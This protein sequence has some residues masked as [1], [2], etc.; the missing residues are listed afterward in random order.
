M[1]IKTY[2]G[3]DIVGEKSHC[4]ATNGGRRI[5]YSWGNHQ[6]CC[7]GGTD[8][9]LIK[10]DGSGNVLWSKT[11]GGTGTERAFTVQ[12]TIDAG[13]IIGGFTTSSGA[14]GNDAL[15]IKT[16]ASGNMLWAQTYGGTLSDICHSILQT[17]D[18]G[19]IFTGFTNS[20]G[21]GNSDV[22]LVKTDMDGN[23]LWTKA[24]GGTGID[25]GNSYYRTTDGGYIIA[26]YTASYGAGSNDVI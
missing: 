19:Y 22:Y 11:F 17:P 15:L 8:I 1:W 10:T 2:G 14:G 4:W 16:D 13:Y 5:Y 24:Y 9:L 25:Q 7:W 3:N 20:F 26:G 23:I 12:Q 6:L 21:A 18:Q